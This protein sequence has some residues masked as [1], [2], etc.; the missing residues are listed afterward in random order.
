MFQIFVIAAVF[1]QRSFFWDK[2]ELFSIGRGGFPQTAAG[3]GFA[4]AAWQDTESHA[5]SGTDPGADFGEIY[6]SC[7]IM[8]HSGNDWER[9]TRIVGPFPYAGTEP[10]IFSL[11]VDTRDRIFLCI[12][13][14]P[15]KTEIY[16]SDDRGITWV[17]SSLT[18]RGASQQEL[19][20]QRNIPVQDEEEILVPKL[21][22]MSDGSYQ[23]FIVRNTG[24]SITLF[25][26]RSTDGLHWMPFENFVTEPG[27][28]F[29]FLP[30]HCVFQGRD[31]IVFQSIITTSTF[32][33]HQLFLKTSSDGGK[34]WSKAR[35]ITDFMDPFNNTTAS[36]DS[37]NNE[38]PHLSVSGDRVFLVWERRYAAGSPSIYGLLLDADG[39]TGAPELINTTFV[40]CNN[41]IGFT[42][43]GVRCVT[44]FDNRRG[45]NSVF[46]ALRT[47]VVWENYEMSRGSITAIFPRP[48]QSGGDLY[49]FWQEM[50]ESDNLVESRI[51]VLGPD[52]ICPPPVITPV[53]FT[54]GAR[55]SSDVA[56]IIWTV[57]DDPSG[58]EGF[59]WSWSRD[60][61]AEPPKKRMGWA[62]MTAVD[63]VANED[64]PWYFKVRAQD[65][66][67]NWSLPAEITFVRDTTPPPPV[68]IHPPRL[69]AAGF[70]AANTF[71]LTW[72]P[73]PADDLEGYAWSM[74]YM[75]EASRTAEIPAAVLL[76]PPQALRIM[77][78]EPRASFENHDDGLW[79]F[80]VYPVDDVG[81][82]GMGASI[83]IKLNKYIPHTFITWIDYGQDYM[84]DLEATLIGR[85]FS[86]SGNVR[87]IYFQPA[88]D[89]GAERV[90]FFDAGDFV[91]SGDRQIVLRRV[92][93]LKA[94]HYY[95][96]VE[97]PVRG[98]ARS[99]S[100]ITVGRSLTYKFGDFT[101]YWE[102]SWLVKF[103]RAFVFDVWTA[104]FALIMIF[105]TVLFVF[106]VRGTAL[107][108]AE[109]R[110]LRDETRALLQGTDMPRI[111]KQQM[112][113]LRH[114]LG[115]R[116]KLASF[117][118]ALVIL[119]TGMVSMPLYLMM[120]ANQ[121]QT[122]LQSLWDRSAV[123]LD[124]IASGARTFLP[125]NN[126]LELGFLPDQMT[127]VREAHYVTISGF[128]A[129]GS[130]NAD[131]VWASNDN[132]LSSKI[133]TPVFQP[134][135]SRIAD[136]VSTRMAALET[137][138]NV[139]ARAE[140]GAMAESVA[141]LYRE[142]L[143]LTGQNTEEAR[144]QLESIDAATSDLNNRISSA[145]NE[146]SAAI[147]AEPSFD[148][149]TGSIKSENYILFKPVMFRQT[150][151]DL[152]VRGWVR[153]EI[154]SDLIVTAIDAAQRQTLMLIL[155]VALA[156]IALGGA[157]SFILA[158]FLILPIRSLVRHVE[159]IRDTEDKAEL[160]GHDI[161]TKTS[162]EI[163]V[164]GA[165]IN[166]M[167]HELAKAASASKDLTIG[168]EIQKKFIPLEIDSGGNKLTSGAHETPYAQFFGYYEGAKG[169]SGDYFDYRNL[170]GRYYAIIK[171]DVAG[172][173]VPA[174]LIMIQVATMFINFFRQWKPDEKG[175]HID[176]LVYEINFFIEELGF[177]G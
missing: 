86:E 101:R 42:H 164:L 46:T 79:R 16:R 25:S 39:T 166:E 87:R 137:E 116:F 34:S 142:G 120:S 105:C 102:A 148:I 81:N 106:T 98:K 83:Y 173:G 64:G 138:L 7:A 162:D 31:M 112:K 14:T 90:L 29:N 139:R 103:S 136:S 5:P 126:V 76:A 27:M 61:R 57:P 19:A 68:T 55:V 170:D 161:I 144:R 35:R 168:K 121:R 88:D 11:I 47:G 67:G 70:V 71:S 78:M 145:L 129:Q 130:L 115:L 62:N 153:L 49:V 143:Q 28:P 158:T 48:V 73:S 123:L 33:S 174:A 89:E 157:L 66:A 127:A 125:A 149:H 111:R 171:C 140:I 141:G 58:I 147:Y 165:T 56:R 18:T 52:R 176:A 133:N 132:V 72:A 113:L 44:W 69:D 108:L 100:P 23:L 104:V 159:I 30:Y 122:L 60:A 1:A 82:A 37:F 118:V 109:G 9:Y 175:M 43:K 114:G 38:R 41:P 26:S 91:V 85:G 167:T 119:V 92:E 15:N 155:Y 45:G 110:A 6:I 177:K 117:T 95:V 84:G 17:H 36:P 124:S 77:S 151:S 107:V 156:A 13:I 154:S 3:P 97:H 54:G 150:G 152:Y 160:V 93:N 75:E 12:A 169:V 24:Q 8:P 163:G 146:I 21:F 172:K 99:P 50:P 4:I 22:Q 40:Y 131:H 53:N 96:V 128:G 63:E 80:T 135:I 2:P 32:S 74:E 59:S 94:G 51:Y 20:K 134:G 10:S 65:F